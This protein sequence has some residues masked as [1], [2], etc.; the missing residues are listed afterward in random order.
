MHLGDSTP[1]FDNSEEDSSPVCA[2]DMLLNIGTISCGSHQTFD[3]TK[4]SYMCEEQS[5]LV[6][7]SNESN[8]YTSNPLTYNC[9]NKLEDNL[10][11][12]SGDSVP[13]KSSLCIP[14]HNNNHPDSDEYIPERS[15]LRFFNQQGEKSNKRVTMRS[16]GHNITKDVRF[17]IGQ[18]MVGFKN[19]YPYKTKKEIALLISKRLK[20]EYP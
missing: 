17:R 19:R 9:S 11:N 12:N 15:V 20:I 6:S 18:L 14:I 5:T 4:N 1:I 16:R 3:D 7:F 8:Q 13:Y 10:I 2:G